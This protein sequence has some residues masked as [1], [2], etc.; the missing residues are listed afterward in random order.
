[1]APSRKKTSKNN[2]KKKKLAA[3][4]K[5]FD[6][7]V[8]M[9]IDQLQTNGQNLLKELDNLYN[10]ENLRLPLA[11]RE[12]NWLDYFAK[13]GSKKALEEAATAD[14]ELSEINK[15][16]AE[17]IQT[18]FRIVKAEKSKQDIDA[19]EETELSLL[20]VAKK[21]K[22]DDKALEESEPEHENVNPKIGKMKTSTK[23]V[24][25]SKSRRAPS[26]RVKRI[27]KRSSKN[28]FVTPALGRVPN[29]C[30]WGRTATVT[31]KFDSRLFKTPGL[32]TPAARE[33]VYIV[34]A[35]G[36]PLANSND[37]IITVPVGGG[38]SMRL[39]ASEL[40]KR[41]LS[42]LNPETLG[43]MKTLS[44]RLAQACSSTNTQR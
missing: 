6:R 7:E 34:S 15:L 10:I 4:L 8:Q 2:V 1:M 20:P 37:V 19:I 3:F 26:A 35:N 14:L 21:R 27:S 41:N 22:Q 39:A 11:L 28:N 25:V 17:V 13:G 38:E 36:S 43:I 9:R 32:R 42:H 12:M 30:T 24:P 16:T 5:D 23:K 40:T 18:P 31:P 44:V 29:A 33:Q